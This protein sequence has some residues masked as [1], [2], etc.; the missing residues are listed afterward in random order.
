[1]SH[2]EVKIQQ[3][4]SLLHLEKLSQMAVAYIIWRKTGHKE[5]EVCG[6]Y[7]KHVTLLSS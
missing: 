4:R 5:N 2:D 3:N 6:A 7:D 1:M